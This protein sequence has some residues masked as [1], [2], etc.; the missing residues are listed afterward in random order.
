MTT[1]I[2]LLATLAMGAL[3]AIQPPVNAELGRRTSDL[4]AAFVSVGIS[5]AAL[6]LIFLL[7]GDFGSL[8]RVGNT[9]P[10]YLAG[11]LCGALFVAVSLVTVRYLGA[12]ATAGAFLCAQLI[13]AAILDQLGVLGLDQIALSPVRLVGITALVAGTVLVTIR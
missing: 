11:G 2:A 5:F 3:V 12:A 7:F 8:T 13:V 10:I 6:G 1:V 4:A 9:P